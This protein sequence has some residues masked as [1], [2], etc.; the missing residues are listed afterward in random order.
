VGYLYRAVGGYLQGVFQSLGAGAEREEGD[1]PKIGLDHTLRGKTRKEAARL[2]F[3][4][5]VCFFLFASWKENRSVNLQISFCT[6]VSFIGS[7]KG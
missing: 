5:L 4:T 2:F 1:E 7:F 3:E 6:C